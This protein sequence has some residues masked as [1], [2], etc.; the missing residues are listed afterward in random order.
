MFQYEQQA[1][2]SSLLQ[3]FP[4]AEGYYDYQNKRYA[5][6]YEDD[7]GNIR[8]A[9]YRGGNNGAVIGRKTNYCPFWIEYERW[10]R[11]LYPAGQL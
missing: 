2:I 11:Y 5:Y 1:E 8:M 6:N 4:T 10:K 7:I 9:Y 3:F